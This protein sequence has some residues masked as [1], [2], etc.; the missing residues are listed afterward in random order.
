MVAYNLGVGVAVLVA[1]QAVAVTEGVGVPIVGI[2]SVVGVAEIVVIGV[3]GKGVGVW[4]ETAVSVTG[5]VDGTAVGKGVVWQPTNATTTK[6]RKTSLV[7]ITSQCEQFIN[8]SRAFY[9]IVTVWLWI[10]NPIW[11]FGYAV[12]TVGLRDSGIL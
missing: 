5:I 4:L 8:L 11:V 7:A 12:V 3:V 1:G 10:D 2:G 6:I 9:H